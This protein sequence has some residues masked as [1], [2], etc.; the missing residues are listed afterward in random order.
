MPTTASA[1]RLALLLLLLAPG[2]GS[3]ATAAEA[4]PRERPSSAALADMLEDEQTRKRLI[5]DLRSAAAERGEAGAAEAT[6]ATPSLPE[7][8]GTAA[9]EAVELTADRLA[10][11]ARALVAMTAEDAIEWDAVAAAATDLALL[12]VATLAAYVLLRRLERPLYARAGGWVQRAPPESRTVTM[13]FS[14]K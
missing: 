5:E 2:V 12:I 13:H 9:Q 14:A 6:A 8:V 10:D 3:A 4:Q 1:R 11:A 7:R